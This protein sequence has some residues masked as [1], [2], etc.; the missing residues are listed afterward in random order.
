MEERAVELELDLA[1]TSQTITGI[2]PAPT[3]RGQAAQC[4]NVV[5]ICHYGRSGYNVLRSLRAIRAKVFVIHDA[6][7][8]SMR[9]SLRSKTIHAVPHLDDADP[10]RI[11]GIINELHR[12]RGVDSVIGA[13]VESQLL[14]LR[15]RDLLTC[16]VFP[17]ATAEILQTLD[18]KWSFHQLCI[19]HDVPV[20][21]TLLCDSGSE[22][23]PDLIGR[24]LGW[25]VVVKPVVGYGQR[26]III[27]KD[28]A[29]F[30]RRLAELSSGR[31]QAVIVQEY[32]EG[33]DWALGV[34][35]RNGRVEHWAA[36]VCPGQ[37]DT[38]YGIGRFT[39]TEFLD[40]R[41]LA[42]M[43]ERL[44][45]A[46]AFS[47]LANFDLRF[48]TRTDTIRMLECNPRCFNRMLATRAIGVDF[49]RPGLR[50]HAG[51]QPRSLGRASFYPWHELF[52]ARGIKRLLNG[53]W[54]LRPLARDLRDMLDD[55]LV[56][57]MRR[58][59]KEDD[60]D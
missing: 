1:S 19:R 3:T 23:D 54:P 53:K 32:L 51:T 52:T 34:F 31:N 7:A 15:M 18:N 33:P 6:R 41:D 11:A 58:L 30:V 28:R 10:Q 14:I 5:L 49:V 36:W 55:P 9:Y 17:I 60:D 27:L 21:K 38:D 8:A 43:C 29:D 2:C 46:T 26:G 16:P 20:P 48:D 4:L 22:L 25:P 12:K 40:R 59:Q 39:S 24:E 35:A 44:I 47:G 45:D 50:G 56:P 42:D 37:L 13:D 57:I